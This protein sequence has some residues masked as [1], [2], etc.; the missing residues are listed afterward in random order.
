VIDDSSYTFT[1]DEMAVD[2][3]TKLGEFRGN[4]VYRGK[5]TAQGFDLIANNIKTDRKKEI[6]LA[7]EKPLLLLKQGRD[8]IYISADTLYSAR[9]SDL[10]KTRKVPNL[11]D[12]VDIVIDTTRSDS[13]NKFLEAY[14]HVKI[15]SD[16]L[17]AVGDSMFYS[18]KD[19]VFRLFKQPVVWAKENQITGDTIYL[20][21]ANKKPE[22]M[23]VFENAM[24]ISRV[25]STDYFNQLKATT[26]NA[27][28]IDGKIASMRAKGNSE[29]VYYNQDDHKKFIAVNKATS[30]VLQTVFKDNK[31][32]KVTLISNA[33]G[34]MF[35]M[36]QVN[37]EELRVRN[38]KWLDKLRPKTKFDILAN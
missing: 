36:R 38:F 27:L 8:S 6:L 13:T 25:D 12:S 21:T 3:S 23:H 37:H 34:T 24:A 17:Q 28:F 18:L 5:D 22:R 26:I 1:A 10:L 9:L 16:S 29:Y 2:D 30:D 35:P 32:D 14:Y 4:A 20:Y 19:S 31:P 15:F 33:D 11:R 7:T